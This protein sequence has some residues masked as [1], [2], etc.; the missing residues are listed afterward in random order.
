[1]HVCVGQGRQQER[2]EEGHD[3][4][5]IVKFYQIEKAWVRYTREV[6]TFLVTF[7]EL[8]NYFKL[9][10]KK[11]DLKWGGQMGRVYAKNFNFSINALGEWY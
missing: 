3:K 11:K 9:N 4:A 10:K 7:I 5:N 8:L 1:M 6:Y 2:T